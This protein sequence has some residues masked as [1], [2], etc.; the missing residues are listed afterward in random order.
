MSNTRFSLHTLLLLAISSAA[1][2]A[3]VANSL[4]QNDASFTVPIPLLSPLVLGF[5][6]LR[7]SSVLS[8]TALPTGSSS[9][10]PPSTTAYAHTFSHTTRSASPSLSAPGAQFTVT[11]TPHSTHSS[12]HHPP[13]ITSAPESTPS[14]TPI[15]EDA[16]ATPLYLN[17]IIAA[18]TYS[19]TAF[20]PSPTITLR[21]TSSLSPSNI[22]LAPTTPPSPVATPSSAAFPTPAPPSPTTAPDHGNDNLP[23]S[24]NWF[25][26]LMICLAFFSIAL[27]WYFASRLRPY[28]F[29]PQQLLLGLGLGRSKLSDEERACLVTEKPKGEDCNVPDPKASESNKSTG[30][31]SDDAIRAID[32]VIKR[33]STPELNSK[34]AVAMCITNTTPALRLIP[35]PRRDFLSV[36][37]ASTPEKLV[38]VD[39]SPLVYRPPHATG[40]HR[41]N[42]YPEADISALAWNQD[43]LQPPDILAPRS[44]V[45]DTTLADNDHEECDLSDASTYAFLSTDGR[46]PLP[47]QHSFPLISDGFQEW[48][49]SMYEAED[50]SPESHCTSYFE[51][52]LPIS[53]PPSLP[54]VQ[55]TQPTV[56]LVQP[57]SGEIHNAD[58]PSCPSTGTIHIPDM[59]DSGLPTLTSECLPTLPSDSNLSQRPQSTSPTPPS[60]SSLAPQIKLDSL[61]DAWDMLNSISALT[62]SFEGES[63]YIVDEVEDEDLF[64]IGENLML[65]SNHLEAPPPPALGFPRPAEVARRAVEREGRYVYGE[66]LADH[67]EMMRL[68]SVGGANAVPVQSSPLR[69]SVRVSAGSMRSAKSARSNNESIA[70]MYSQ[71]TRI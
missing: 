65:Q 27:S 69:Y 47:S 15:D 33:S 66:E 36:P 25:M 44:S 29:K 12:A 21:P 70:S 51:G 23:P 71:W 19:V 4:P 32:A 37:P 7:S 39:G 8:S 18:D 22:L 55:I 34:T 20:T 62:A 61:S 59:L 9:P 41:Q 38:G 26:F 40:V 3:P 49:I 46:T 57:M 28:E 50:Y 31:F 42:A 16:P 1:F 11:A 53:A 64:H 43:H 60:K 10:A 17:N 56:S 24:M 30:A 58:F 6:H 45:M 13:S 48:S 68:R 67:L 54:M 2:A 5:N 14:S 35:K 63:F 52:P